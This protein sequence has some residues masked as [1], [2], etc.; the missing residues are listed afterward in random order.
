MSL[1]HAFKFYNLFQQDPN[2]RKACYAC[3][4]REEWQ[5]FIKNEGLAFSENEF[6]EV[7]SYSLFRCRIEEE[8]LE[9]RQIEQ[10]YKV[11]TRFNI[12]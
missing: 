4:S 12:Q 10:T 5:L 1:S 8:A 9:V 6:E 3:Q 2:F 7:I 11:L